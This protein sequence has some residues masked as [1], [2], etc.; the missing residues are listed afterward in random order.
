MKPIIYHFT[1]IAPLYRKKLWHTLLAS[2]AFEFHNFFGTNKAMGIKTIDFNDEIFKPHLIRIK[3]LKNY[4]IKGKYL[5]WQKGI[6]R[7]VLFSRPDLVIALGEFPILSNWMAAIICRLRGIKI[8]FIGHGLYGDEKGLKLFL[9]KSFYRLANAHLL[10]ERHAKKNMISNGFVSEKLHVIFNS[11]DY[12]NHKMMRT[13]TS[14]LTKE[15][16]F[17]FFSKSSLPVF[18]FVGRLTK[19]KKI[20][21]LIEAMAELSTK[22]IHANLLVVGDGTEK[23]NLKGKASLMLEKGSYHFFGACY[24]ENELGKFLATSDLCVSPGN[25][26]L[27][28]IHSLSLGTPVCTHNTFHNQGP[29]VESL[30]PG[31]TGVFFN[32]NDTKD[33]EENLRQWLSKEKYNKEEMRK[34]CFK[35]I[36]DYYNPYYQEKVIKNLVEGKAALL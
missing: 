30:E 3:L 2:T 28:A 17:P 18:I 29:E 8:V 19:S 20:N 34:A 33:L 32:E 21:M 36:D 15:V 4:W 11:L 24:D 16:V 5:I 35:I 10:Y 26:G 31:T 1:N 22:G 13:T 9:R 12:D 23:S 6:L 7:K 27:T 25:V 14:D